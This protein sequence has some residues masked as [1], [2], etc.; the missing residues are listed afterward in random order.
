LEDLGIEGRIISKWMSEGV[1]WICLTE[2]RDQ[3]K[4]LKNMSMKL[5]VHRRW[6]I[7]V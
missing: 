2:D 1:D 5:W 3:W 4:T 6:K 7:A